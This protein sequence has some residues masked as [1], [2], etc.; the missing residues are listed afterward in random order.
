[1]RSAFLRTEER[2]EGRWCFGLMGWKK[3]EK[4]GAGSGER[5]GERS[6]VKCLGME[7]LT[8]PS[9]PISLPLFLSNHL[10]DWL[11]PSTPILLTI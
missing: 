1:M 8:F 5:R 7:P 9:P 11:V 3:G 6:D 2:K 10:I 4:S